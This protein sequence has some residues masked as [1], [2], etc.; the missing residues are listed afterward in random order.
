VAQ[1]LLVKVMLAVAD[2]LMVGA[3]AAARLKWAVIT[4]LHLE[5]T[6]TAVTVFQIQSLAQ[7]LITAVAAAGLRV[8]QAD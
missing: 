3:V 6:Q 2:H 8:V 1:V 7:L 5:L 4:I